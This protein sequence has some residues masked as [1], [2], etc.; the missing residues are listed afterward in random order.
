MVAHALPGSL[1]IYQ[2]EELGLPD[3]EIAP[4]FRQD[5][6]FIRSGGKDLG[7]DGARV[8]LPWE[9]DEKNFGFSTG[10][11]WLPQDPSYKNYSVDLEEIN[12][13]SFLNLYKTSLALRKKHLGLGGD[14]EVEWPDSPKGVV[15]FKRS[16]GFILLANTTAES[17][18]VNIKL[19]ATIILQSAEGASIA[20]SIVKIPA[21]T[22]LW[23]QQ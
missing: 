9:A 20:G 23:L 17:L 2:G 15:Y 1:Y 12:K 14:S 8:P 19:A 6:A 4:E 11:S 7:R 13:S 21:D 3:G 5:P 10:T 18:E 22:T 16:G